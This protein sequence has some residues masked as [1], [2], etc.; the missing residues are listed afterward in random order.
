[1]NS[2]GKPG[3]FAICNI[4]T[5]DFIGSLD[6]RNKIDGF[7]VIGPCKA[8]CVL[9]KIFCIICLCFRVK[10]TDEKTVLVRFITV[11]FHTLPSDLFAVR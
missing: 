5:V 7:A 9:I 8:F 11:A 10:I 4:K 2:V 1:M 6:I 3:K